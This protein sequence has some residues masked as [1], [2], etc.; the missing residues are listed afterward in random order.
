MNITII[1]QTIQ[2][3]QN[4]GYSI[5]WATLEIAE[6][7]GEKSTETW[8]WREIYDDDDNLWCYDKN[9]HDNL[10]H[11]DGYLLSEET[12]KQLKI[13]ELLESIDWDTVAND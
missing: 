2:H 7:D 4:D 10:V 11:S 5:L 9:T 1:Y 6:E 12:T 3:Y 8:G 13:R